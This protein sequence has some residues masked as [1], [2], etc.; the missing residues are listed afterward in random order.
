MPPTTSHLYPNG[1]KMRRADVLHCLLIATKDFLDQFLPI[2]PKT[3]F[4]LN[5]VHCGQV[6][7]VMGE[8]AKLSLFTADDWDSRIFRS[9]IDMSKVEEQ[10][11]SRM[12]EAA[13]IFES[14]E[15]NGLWTVSARRLRNA[16]KVPRRREQEQSAEALVAPDAYTTFAT[17]N[18]D[19]FEDTFWQGMSGDAWQFIA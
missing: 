13:S 17:D 12:E 1:C 5:L 14:N 2:P 8:L 3:Y 18:F 4:A 16:R 6:M 10:I 7:Y 11:I 19:F 15:D 9:I